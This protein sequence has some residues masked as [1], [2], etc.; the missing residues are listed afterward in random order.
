MWTFKIGWRK[1]NYMALQLYS[2]YNLYKKET[3]TRMQNKK[4]WF[5]LY[6]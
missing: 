1:Q 3:F 6:Q 2:T 5:F 4:Q